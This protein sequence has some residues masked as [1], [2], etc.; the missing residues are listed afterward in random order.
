MVDGQSAMYLRQRRNDEG[1]KREAKKV[2]ADGE[3]T[4]RDARDLEF[5]N[6]SPD[7]WSNDC[8]VY[9]AVS[10]DDVSFFFLRVAE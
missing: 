5:L 1:A 6:D 4:D 10:S 9:I 2:N 3:G 7:S 8:N